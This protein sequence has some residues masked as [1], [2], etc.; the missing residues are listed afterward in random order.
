MKIRISVLLGEVL[1]GAIA[2]LLVFNGHFEGAIG[3]AGMIAATMDKVIEK[4]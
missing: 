1:I 3:I 4:E 2:I